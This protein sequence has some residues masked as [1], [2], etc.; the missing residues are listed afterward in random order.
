MTTT[1]APREILAKKD[2]NLAV[3]KATYFKLQVD[4]KHCPI[5]GHFG[6][7]TVEGG[8][9]PE[10]MRDLHRVMMFLGY[11]QTLDTPLEDEA[12]YGYIVHEKQRERVTIH[13]ENNRVDMIVHLAG[14]FACIRGTAEGGKI[15]WRGP[16]CPDDWRDE[17][18]MIHEDRD[19]PA[20]KLAEALDEL[21]DGLKA[22]TKELYDDDR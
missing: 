3:R 17:L 4:E 16:E 11:G 20:T 18:D 12:E 9:T 1:R 21:A 2:H 13:I 14:S 10:R 7:H 19:H 8:V 6:T 22:V 5:D 15:D